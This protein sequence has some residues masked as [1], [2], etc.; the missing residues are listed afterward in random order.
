MHSLS[1]LTDLRDFFAANS[2]LAQLLGVAVLVT[3]YIFG[4]RVIKSVFGAILRRKNYIHIKFL[5]SACQVMATIAVFVALLLQFS[6]THALA[7]TVITSSSLLLTVLGFAAQ[8]SL[9]NVICGI[10][11]S[12][13]KPF[14]VGQRIILADQG[15]TGTVEDITLRHTVVRKINNAIAVVPNSV[16]NASVIENSNMGGSDVASFLDLSISYDSNIERAKAIIEQAVL[17]HPLVDQSRYPGRRAQV[18]VRELGDS[19]VHLRTTVWTNCMDDSFL[20]CSQLRQQVKEAFDQAGIQ[21]PYPCMQ[22]LLTGLKEPQ[23]PVKADI[24]DV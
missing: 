5:K 9:N 11:I 23:P 12:A 8:Q 18:L 7:T 19:G 22:V 3:A 10:M 13:F 17:S 20:C 1:V 6:T 14:E 24:G 16:M 2:F 15:I 21:I 4:M